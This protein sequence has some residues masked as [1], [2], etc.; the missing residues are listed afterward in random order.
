[1]QCR[2]SFDVVYCHN[3]PCPQLSHFEV[4]QLG[5]PAEISSKSSIASFPETAKAQRLFTCFDSPR[6]LHHNTTILVDNE[7]PGS[8]G[9]TLEATSRAGLGSELRLA[10]C[11]LAGLMISPECT[12]M[13]HLNTE[14]HTYPV[15]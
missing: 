14:T 6:T 8:R 4:R 15:E 1:M 10:S 12:I 5:F 9:V 3:N 11:A 13:G 2:V 7:A